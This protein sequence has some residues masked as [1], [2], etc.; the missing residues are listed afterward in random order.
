MFP[1]RFHAPSR[2]IIAKA[3]SLCALS[4]PLLAIC[5]P[6]LPQQLRWRMYYAPTTSV[7]QKSA[8]GGD[9]CGL[10]SPVDIGFNVNKGHPTR[11]RLRAEAVEGSQGRE[12]RCRIC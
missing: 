11:M 2:P 3:V 5:C 1:D 6:A 8:E 9:I 4:K 7:L 12:K 10:L